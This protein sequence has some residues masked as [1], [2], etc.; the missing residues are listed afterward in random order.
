MSTRSPSTRRS[1]ILNHIGTP[2]DQLRVRVDFYLYATHEV[3]TATPV[4]TALRGWGIDAAFVL[5]P[6]GRHVAVGSVPDPT[7]GWLDVKDRRLAPLM[8]DELHATLAA[9]VEASEVP[10]VD[11]P[12][13][14]AEIALTTQNRAWLRMYDGVRARLA[15]G[16]GLVQESYGHGDVNRGFDVVLAHGSFSVDATRA[17]VPGVHAVAAGFP[18]WARYLRGERDPRSARARLG[19]APESPTLLYAPTWAHRSSVEAMADV[20]PD[21]REAWQVVVKPHHNSLHLE[22]GRIGSLLELVPDCDDWARHDLVPYV[23]AADVVVTDA[24]SGVF[25]ESLLARTPVIGISTPGDR[26]HPGAYECA[27]IVDDAIHVRDA[28]VRTEWS[29][30][31]AAADRWVRAMFQP[32]G[33]HDD[34]RAALMLLQAVVSRPVRLCRRTEQRARAVARRLVRPGRLRPDSHTMSAS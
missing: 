24:V 31:S 30:Y 26:L 8:T 25:T 11:A 22:P 29:Q 7:R 15:Y 4:L 23:A 6:P 14:N 19:L 5:E 16:V 9:L 13:R 2:A 3:A 32:S 20:I 27:P 1:F 33:G 18:K 10:L 17:V 34:E 21:L 28:L 12:R